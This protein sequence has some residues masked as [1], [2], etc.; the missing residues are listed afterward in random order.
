M[1]R[2]Q[3][4]DKKTGE[5][6]KK[7]FIGLLAILSVSAFAGEK[8]RIIESKLDS[9]VLKVKVLYTQGV[10]DLTG[11][12]PLSIPYK[13]D[14]T[15]NIQCFELEDSSKQAVI[16]LEVSIRPQQVQ[17]IREKHKTIKLS[18]ETLCDGD[19][20]TS[21]LLNDKEVLR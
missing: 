11:V 5:F 8:P 19:Q 16:D 2:I 4:L 7:L 17:S 9:G 15:K 12:A 1:G 10:M 18:L 6:M 3:T 13:H 20:V 21:V 14:W